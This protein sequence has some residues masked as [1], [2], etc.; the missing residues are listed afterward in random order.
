MCL[1]QTCGLSGPVNHWKGTAVSLRFISGVGWSTMKM[2]SRLGKVKCFRVTAL[3]R[4]L[5]PLSPSK[6]FGSFY[7]VHF[8][9]MKS[10][11]AE[12]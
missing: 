8:N 5:H 3:S 11:N 12:N 7:V 4:K 2:K 1:K 9:F 10:L 6:W